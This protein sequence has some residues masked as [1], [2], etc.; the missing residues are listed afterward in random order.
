MMSIVKPALF[1]LVCMVT[2]TAFAQD[3]SG[4][5][6]HSENPVYVEIQFDGDTGTGTVRQNDK[7]PEAAGKIV[8]KDLVAEAGT[9]TSWQGQVYAEKLE[10][11]KDAQLSLPEP[12]QMQIKVKV[13]FIS[14]TVKWVR[15]EALPAS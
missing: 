9:S 1:A 6:K 11:F 12:D 14:R 4:L 15:V 2:S 5:W 7:R 8:F 13:G 3:L 10:A